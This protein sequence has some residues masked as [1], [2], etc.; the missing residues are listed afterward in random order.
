MGL[1]S[2]LLG[3]LGGPR[4][5]EARGTIPVQPSG[6]RLTRNATVRDDWLTLVQPDFFGRAHRSSNK[7]WIVGCNDSDGVGRGGYRE[8][9]NG[10]AVLV[11]HQSDTVIHELTCFARPMDAAVSDAGDYIVQDSGFGSALQ[12]DVIALNIE[13]HERYR[14]HY[15]ANVFN[16]G[17]SKCGK[18]AAVQTANAP[19]DDGNLLEVLD[20]DRGCVVFSLQPATGWADRYSFDVDVEGHLKAIGVEHKN[21]GSFKYSASGEFQ[22]TQAFQAARLDKGD[23]STKLMAARDLLKTAATQDDARKALSTA[24]AALVEGAKDRPDWGAIAHRVRGE[25]YELLGQLPEALAAFDKALSL[26]P[27]VGVQ[28]RAVALHKKLGTG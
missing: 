18:Y 1:F 26:N 23:Y 11:D 17:L 22:D 16:M 24:D 21:L 19:S 12:G 7:R 3:M 13:G 25:S 8:S 10:R 4:K 15:R 9:G 2:R 14:R 28:K 5:T 27:K 20:L 6:G